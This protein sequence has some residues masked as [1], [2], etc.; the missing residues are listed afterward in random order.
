MAR[1]YAEGL[2]TPRPD[3]MR[4]IARWLNVPLAWLAHGEG[5]MDSGDSA[6]DLGT[7][8]AC[9][10][11]VSAAQTQSGITLSVERQAQLVASL[12][13]E[14]KAGR[15]QTAAGLTSMLKALFS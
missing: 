1:R 10:R 9:I 7:L 12:Y 11:A 13:A 3:A 5:E 15:Q 8:E 6:I 4:A 14:A 2:A